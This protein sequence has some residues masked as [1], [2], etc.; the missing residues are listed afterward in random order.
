MASFSAARRRAD[1][2]TI[3]GRARARTVAGRLGVALRDARRSTG[4]TQAQVA[5][6]AGVSQQLISR[7]ELGRG[8]DASLETWACVAAAVGEQLVGFLE[9]APGATPPRDIE[10]LRRQSALIAA[11]SAG[12]WTAHPELAIDPGAIRSRSIDVALIRRAAR[13]AIVVEVWDWFDDVGASLRGLDAK[14][15]VLTSRL[16]DEPSNGAERVGGRDAWRVRGLF[17]V[18][19]TR[20]NRAIVAELRPLFAARFTGRSVEWLRTLETAAAMPDG[21]GLLWSDRHGRLVPSRLAR[22][23]ATAR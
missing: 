15:E 13:E 4:R 22:P 8:Q 1:P 7:L 18:R 2:S 11:A 19:D 3:A 5:I 16:R 6:R 21:H 12:G 20:R 10:H 14:I 23:P 9:W 17:V